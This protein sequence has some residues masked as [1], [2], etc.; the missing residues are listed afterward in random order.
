MHKQAQIH[1]DTHTSCLYGYILGTWQPAHNYYWFYI[2][3]SHDHSLY[4][5][6][7]FQYS[8]AWIHL[9]MMCSIWLTLKNGWKI[10]LG[11]LGASTNDHN[12]LWPKFLSQLWSHVK[13][14]L[15]CIVIQ[16]NK[17]YILYGL[18]DFLLKAFIRIS[19]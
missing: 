9:M 7:Q 16:L 4:C 19:Y 2:P 5:F 11:P 17:I 13:N 12:D 15:F 1:R 3:C 10:R 8:R 18:T 6:C 14:F